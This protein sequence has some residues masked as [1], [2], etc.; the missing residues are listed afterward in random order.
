MLLSTEVVREIH[1]IIII[2]SILHVHACIIIT[3][4]NVSYIIVDVLY[5]LYTVHILCISLVS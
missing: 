3:Q 1:M 5:Y 4:N 2:M